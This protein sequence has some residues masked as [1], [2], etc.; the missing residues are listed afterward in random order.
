MTASEDGIYVYEK[1]NHTYHYKPEKTIAGHFLGYTGAGD[2]I[3][4]ITAICKSLNFS[5]RE[6][7]VIACN[8]ASVYVQRKGTDPVTP[9]QL[10]KHIDNIEAKIF[11]DPDELKNILN[12]IGGDTALCNGCYDLLS[13]HHL[14]TLKFASENADI[15]LVAVNSDESVKRLKGESR[16]IIPL[17]E[18]MNMIRPS[19]LYK[20]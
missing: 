11:T 7:S 14:N 3:S 9:Y 18:R 13:T 6:S 12:E 20:N 10:K 1:N 16:P 5:Y 17:A 19:N 15:V 2:V 4:G 8:V